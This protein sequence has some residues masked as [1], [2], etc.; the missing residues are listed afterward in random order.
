MRDRRLWTDTA[1]THA[2]RVQARLEAGEQLSLA[3]VPIGIKAAE[4][5]GSIQSQR[6]TAAGCVPVGATPFP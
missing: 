3:G 4:G 1:R 5:I 6:M 2:A